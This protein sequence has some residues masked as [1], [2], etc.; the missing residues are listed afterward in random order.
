MKILKSNKA[1]TASTIDLIK[2]IGY[3]RNNNGK[4]DVCVVD[5]PYADMQLATYDPEDDEYDILQTVDSMDDAYAAAN[6]QFKTQPEFVLYSNDIEASSDLF[7]IE[8]GF[9]TRDDLITYIEEPLQEQIPEIR[10]CRAYMEQ[11]GKGQYTLSVDIVTDDLDTTVAANI[12]MRK[13]RRS[14]DLGKYLPTIIN[15]YTKEEENLW[16]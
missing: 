1:I 3:I 6:A 15:Q 9:F 10:N 13:I 5:T 11:N 7:G 12:D 8:D 4:F 2:T 14:S 16:R